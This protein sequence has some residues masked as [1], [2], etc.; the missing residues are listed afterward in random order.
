MPIILQKAAAPLPF[1]AWAGPSLLCKWWVAADGLWLQPP[2]SP[3][4]PFAHLLLHKSSLFTGKSGFPSF[5]LPGGKK[6]KP[7]L[8]GVTLTQGNKL[9]TKIIT[10]YPLLV[11]ASDSAGD[12]STSVRVLQSLGR[13]LKR[14]FLGRKGGSEI[15]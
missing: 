13:S 1:K 14:C 5:F 2:F 8:A 3:T 7:K 6:R 15:V 10:S 11:P 9:F 12:R 4:S